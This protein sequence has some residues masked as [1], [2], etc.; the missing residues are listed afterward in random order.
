MPISP[1]DDVADVSL[2]TDEALLERVR[3]LVEGAYRQQLWFMFL[4]ER[5]RQLPLL[6]PF[7]VPDRP[8]EEHRDRLDPFVAHLVDEVQPRS[9]VVVLERPGPDWLT[10]SD[11]E[12]FAV[13]DDACRA[14]GVVRRGPIVAYDDG[15]RWIAA[16]DLLGRTE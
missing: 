5:D 9:I 4:D 2:A 11:R 10:V 14:A 6:I 13:I 8:D 3:D 15:F 1:F 16:E 12:W 7:D